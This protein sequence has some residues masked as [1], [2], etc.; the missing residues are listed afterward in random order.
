M[1]RCRDVGDALTYPR[2][3]VFSRVG[4]RGLNVFLWLMRSTYRTY[5]HD[6]RR[7]E[8]WIAAAGF[9]KRYENQT[10]I[11]LTQVYVRE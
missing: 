4:T 10:M 8:A 3:H 5:V 11:W 1:P 6:P 2:D 9:K 7:I